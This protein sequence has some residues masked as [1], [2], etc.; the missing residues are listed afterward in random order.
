M[1]PG[2]NLEKN[3]IHPRIKMFEEDPWVLPPDAT[4]VNPAVMAFTNKLEATGWGKDSPEA[5]GYENSFRNALA[6]V[7]EQVSRS[8]ERGN[9][10]IRF[11]INYKKLRITIVYPEQSADHNLAESNSKRV[12]YIKR[13]FSVSHHKENGNDALVLEK[14]RKFFDEMK[15]ELPTDITLLKAASA[16]LEA[17]L[18]SFGWSGDELEHALN[19]FIELLSNAIAHGNLGVVRLRESK[20]TIYEIALNEQKRHP[21][22]MKKIVWV[23]FNAIDKDTLS[24]TISDEGEG[25][26]PK[27]VPDPLHRD[28]IMKPSGRGIFNVKTLHGFESVVYRKEK[29]EKGKDNMAVTA[30]KHRK[31]AA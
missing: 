14:T 5:Y 8:A 21:E 3:P 28:N 13:H 23:T 26:D 11:D 7:V 17:R 20:E 1:Q 31:S 24:F 19:G 12:S 10:S 27:Q 9:L 22:K 4:L 30:V 25:F 2:I 15:W 18:I 16:A 29:D 6:E